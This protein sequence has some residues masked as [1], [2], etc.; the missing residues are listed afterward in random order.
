MP[1]VIFFD[2]GQREGAKGFLLTEMQGKQVMKVGSSVFL[3]HGE[4]PEKVGILRQRIHWGKSIQ[5]DRLKAEG[6]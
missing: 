2:K 3:R 6:F 1:E 4:I 5:V